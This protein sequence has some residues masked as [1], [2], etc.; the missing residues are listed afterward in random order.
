MAYT[1]IAI[2]VCHC[3]SLRCRRVHGWLLYWEAHLDRPMIALTFA[4]RYVQMPSCSLSS[5]GHVTWVT[6]RIRTQAKRVAVSTLS[7]PDV[8]IRF[9][10]P[11]RSAIATVLFMS[12]NEHR[13]CSETS[14]WLTI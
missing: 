3:A 13:G 5:Q 11:S 7:F 4:W 6:Q 8:S 9:P 2:R 1:T 10:S 14:T 12:N